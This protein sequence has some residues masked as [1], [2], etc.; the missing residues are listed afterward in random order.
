MLYP[1][2]SY[3]MCYFI[4]TKVYQVSKTLNKNNISFETKKLAQK[5]Q[6]VKNSKRNQNSASVW[7]AMFARNW[8]QVKPEHSHANNLTSYNVPVTVITQIL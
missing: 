1:T 6:P 7:H 8:T 2:N 5:T 4:K 3:R